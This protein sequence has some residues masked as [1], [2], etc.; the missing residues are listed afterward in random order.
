MQGVIFIGIQGSGKSSFYLQNFFKTHMRISMDMLKTRHRE[1]LLLSACLAAK[2][3][4]VIDNTNPTQAERERYIAAFKQ[5]RFHISGYFFATELNECLSRNADRAGK[6]RVPEIGVRGTYKK[7]VLPQY[8]EGFDKL[9]LVTA[10]LGSYQ[11]A[12]WQ[13]EA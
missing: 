5:S 10:Q 1:T 4:V 2:Q 7:L 9:Y 11:V 12:E 8:R 13:G 3:P 6:E